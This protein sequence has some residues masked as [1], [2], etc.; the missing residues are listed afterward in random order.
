MAAV[1]LTVTV[2]VTAI[3]CTGAWAQAG[4][5]KMSRGD[6]VVILKRPATAARAGEWFGPLHPG[7]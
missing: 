6:A 7:N 5:G 3:W 4:E 2:L 1:F